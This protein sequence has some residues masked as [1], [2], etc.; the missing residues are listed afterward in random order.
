MLFYL[1]VEN[2]VLTI[3]III[4]FASFIFYIKAARTL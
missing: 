4:R 1:Q 3:N 2:Y